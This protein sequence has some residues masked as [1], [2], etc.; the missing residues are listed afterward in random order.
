MTAWPVIVE[1]I[2]QSGHVGLNETLDRYQAK[3]FAGYTTCWVRAARRT[4]RR[5]AV[6]DGI[7]GK[8]ESDE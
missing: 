2:R 6:R 1:R 7:I 8:E 3:L 5:R 4:I